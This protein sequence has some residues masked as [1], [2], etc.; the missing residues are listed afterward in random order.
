MK[1]TVLLFL[2][3][4]VLFPPFLF[5]NEP[6]NEEFSLSLQDAIGIAFKNNKDIQI[7]EQDISFAKAGIMS[8]RSQFL[9]NVDA[10]YS[11]THNEAVSPITVQGTKKDIGLFTGYKN[12]NLVGIGV[13]QTVYDGGANIA[14]FRQA[15]LNLKVSSETLRT[16]KLDVE[17]ETKRLYYG[18]MLAYET[19]RIAQDLVGQAKSH[20]E[21]V[22]AKFGQGTSSK[23]DVL[24]SSVQVSKL[25]PQFI[26]SVNDIRL[27]MAD[28]NKALGI[29]IQTETKARDKFTYSLIEIKEDEFLR[30]AYLTAPEM[31]VK[32]LGIDINK[33]AINI[34]KAGYRPQLT[35]DLNYFYR[36]NNWNTMFNTKHNNWNA[37]IALSVPIFDGF[38]SKAKVDEAKARYTQSNLD[39]ANLIDQIAV[40]IRQA[41]LD[42]K[43]AQ[44][45][46]DSQKDNVEEAREALRIANVG[47]DNG[48]NTNLDVLDAQ[49]SLAQVE[50][51]LAQGIYDYLLAKAFLERTIGIS[52]IEEAKK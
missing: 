30:Q 17:F 10:N 4:S 29:K 21:D 36:S 27:V 44:T 16:K 5:C 47:Y 39:K 48:V 52:Y 42:L 25:M 12:D 37:G 41:C 13:T 23:F 50:Q 2:L 46:I 15:Q 28:L 1:K 22:N 31:T 51:N 14:S 45:I 49:V 24:Q 40:N 9:P 6:S 35:A 8:A 26:S 34:A 7:S 3:F 11:Y 20:Y 33:W 43:E 19:E 38:S 32:S 18:L